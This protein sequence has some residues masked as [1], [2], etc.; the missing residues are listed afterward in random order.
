MGY[1][2]S[3]DN[4]PLVDLGRYY[5]AIPDWWMFAESPSFEMFIMLITQMGGWLNAVL[6]LL[7]WLTN[8]QKI[9]FMG[10]AILT[11]GIFWWSLKRESP[12]VGWCIIMQ[13]IWQVGWRTQWIHALET[14]LVLCVWQAWHRN[15]M[16]MM[17][18]IVSMLA[19]WLRPSALIWLLGMCLWDCVRGRVRGQH[20]ILIGSCLGIILIWP[21]IMQYVLGKMSVPEIHWSLIDQ[22]GRHGGLIP[23]VLMM[24][25]VV[26]RIS[27]IETRYWMC[28]CWVLMAL[29]ISILAGVGLDNF[30]LFFV[31]LAVLSG[32]VELSKQRQM[33]VIA[34]SITVH[35]IPFLSLL[36]ERMSPV[37]H[38][39][40]IRDTVYDFQRP[41]KNPIDALSVSDLHGILERE[42]QF[43]QPHCLV[44]TTGFLFHPHRESHGRLA[45]LSKDLKQL[46]LKRQSCGSADR[47]NYV[48]FRWRLYKSVMKHLFGPHILFRLHKCLKIS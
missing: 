15:R 24:I 7:I 42:C 1:Y 48:E 26:C 19:V 9:L 11:S 45:L 39:N 13:P 44:V 29:S 32:S 4:R 35:L 34:L 40:T 18:G 28:A 33:V 21:H 38:M 10:Y 8:D 27:N 22:I 5:Q 47:N 36:P 20:H 6:A 17:T 31:G 12:L 2:W 37:V 16:S 14:S 25:I 41:I 3:Q 23:T 46:K 30:P 43:S